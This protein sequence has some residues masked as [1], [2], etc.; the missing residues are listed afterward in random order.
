MD[1]IK[2]GAVTFALSFGKTEKDVLAQNDSE[3][4]LAQNTA[5]VN[6]YVANKLMQDLKEGRLT[7]EVKQFRKH[8]YEI[9]KASSRYKNGKL[10][11][12]D[13]IRNSKLVKGDPYD[14]YQVEVVFDNKAIGH[15][16]FEQTEVRPLKIQRGVVPRFKLENFT[17]TVHVKNVDGNNKLLA[18]YIPKTNENTLISHELERLKESKKISDLVNFTKAKFTTQDSEM[19]TFEYRMLAFDSVVDYNNNYIVKMFA[20]CVTDGRW[21]AEWTQIID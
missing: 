19:L 15:S 12:E 17:S 10:L 16:L 3:A 13:E 21:A 2:K 9:L 1:W 7:Q 5:I 18:F 20:E 8:H 11:S 4:I 14:S 6:P